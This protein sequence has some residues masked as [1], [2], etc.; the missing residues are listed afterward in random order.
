MNKNISKN[1][2]NL[3]RSQTSNSIN[4]DYLTLNNSEIS[5]DFEFQTKSEKE[6]PLLDSLK[7]K[8]INSD[9]S[10]LPKKFSLH[11]LQR[12]HSDYTIKINKNNKIEKDDTS[13][14]REDLK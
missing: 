1:I 14:F 12:K 7:M 2:G 5:E 9:M 11:D 6:T 13:I 3:N 10:T 8:K 4:E